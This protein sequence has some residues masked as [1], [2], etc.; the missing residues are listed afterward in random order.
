MSFTKFLR[1][2]LWA[3]ILFDFIAGGFTGWIYETV[4][5][6]VY[7]HEFVNRGVLVIPVLP[8]YGLFAVFVVPLFRK[9]RNPFL[10]GVTGA[11]LATLFEL[12]GAFLTESLFGYRLWT[13][14]HWPLNFFGGRIS[15]ISSLVFGA[16]CVLFLKAIHPLGIKLNERYGLKF[17]TAVGIISALL[18]VGCFL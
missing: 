12:A 18:L 6:S 3:V 10:I 15:L 14:E 13:Y 1:D 5:T 8:I 9:M 17:Q 2:G 16:L 4:I 11:V 7:F